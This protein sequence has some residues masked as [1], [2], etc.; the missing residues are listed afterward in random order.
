M[1]LHSIERSPVPF[2]GAAVCIVATHYPVPPQASDA[3]SRHQGDADAAEEA[4]TAL[5]A[6]FELEEATSRRSTAAPPS[7][8]LMAGALLPTRHSQA[9]S[10]MLSRHPCAVQPDP[11][12]FSLLQSSPFFQYSMIMNQLFAWLLVAGQPHCHMH[13]LDGQ[14][15]QQQQQQPC[16]V[17]GTFTLVPGSPRPHHN[18]WLSSTPQELLWVSCSVLLQV[19]PRCR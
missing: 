3:M 5:S 10:S 17:V 6:G 8:Y 14:Q 1:Q 13:Q 4:L 18:T 7:A 11:A 16:S 2:G 9:L 19:S 12:L 15:Q